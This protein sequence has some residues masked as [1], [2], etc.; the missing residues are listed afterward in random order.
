MDVMAAPSV[1]PESFGMV[2]IEALA[3]GVYPVLTHQSAFQ[4]IGERVSAGL[5]S[6]DLG[7]EPVRLDE[8]AVD[9]IAANVNRYLDLK[10]SL[11]EEGKFA[12]LRGNLRRIVEEHFSWQAVARK[13]LRLYETAGPVA[14]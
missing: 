14:R 10:H 6:Y 8:C 13:Y 7:I 9:A 4:E 5:A 3:S 11:I 12:E 1:F 2:A